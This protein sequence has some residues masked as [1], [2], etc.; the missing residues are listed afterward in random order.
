MSMS[1]IPTTQ[2]ESQS[3]LQSDIT[4]KRA[5]AKLARNANDAIKGLLAQCDTHVKISKH[6]NSEFA[7]DFAKKHKSTEDEI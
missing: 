3:N 1:Q 4:Q 6:V 2:Y 5:Y 7:S